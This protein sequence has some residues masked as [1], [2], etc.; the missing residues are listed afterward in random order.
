[1]QL[2]D[3]GW[4]MHGTSTNEDLITG[5]P[6]KCA[7]TDRPMTALV[8]DLKQRGL[9]DETIVIWSGEFGRTVMNEERNGSK[10]LGRDHHPNCFTIWIAG[11]GF[12][13]GTVFGSTDEW[14]AHVAENPV[15]VHELQATV[16][17]AL[18]LNHQRLEFRSQGRDMRLTD[19]YGKVRHELLA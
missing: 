17:H 10:L 3:W 19:V 14:G 13:G 15:S 6:N 16:L 11:G 18:G 9:L 8:R 1:V 4:D 12:K 7:G 2:F 5:L